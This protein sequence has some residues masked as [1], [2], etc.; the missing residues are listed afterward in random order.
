MRGIIFDLDGVLV[1][2]EPLKFLA[3]VQVFK[4]RFTVDIIDDASR[5]GKHEA[6][7]MEF[8]LQRY[9]VHANVAELI[10][11]KRQQYHT[12][13]SGP[14]LKPI[15]G[16]EDF[17]A[18]LYRLG[19]LQLGLAS[20]SDHESVNI[21]LKRF[22]WQ[23]YFTAVLSVESVQRPKPD[24]DIYL[25]AAQ[26]MKLLPA[27]CLVIEDSPAGIAAAKS[28]GMRCIAI[29]TGVPPDRLTS[30]D[31]VVRNFS[32]LTAEKIHTIIS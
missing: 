24:P 26:R 5:I 11:A 8:F 18:M 32:E 1:D 3:Y 30:A 12:I 22:T 6:A 27:H 7:V 20:L 19:G 25:Q 4:Q 9:G 29:A 15:A 31:V 21:I 23:R 14:T 10:A 13:I 16:A 2:T 28:A 17:L